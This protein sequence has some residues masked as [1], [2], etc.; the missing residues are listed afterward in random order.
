[1]TQ[2]TKARKREVKVEATKIPRSPT[3]EGLLVPTYNEGSR[4]VQQ[5][6]SFEG[7]NLVWYCI[8]SVG[9]SSGTFAWSERLQRDN[10]NGVQN[11]SSYCHWRFTLLCVALSQRGHVTYLLV[12]LIDLDVRRRFDVLRDIT[13]HPYS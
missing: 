9:N 6:F 11:L 10:N 2:H 3:L 13:V 1:M 5:S 4:D 8:K 7:W 12:Y